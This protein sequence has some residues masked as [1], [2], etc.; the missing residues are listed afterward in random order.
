MLEA[1]TYSEDDV[2][3]L[4]RNISWFG[5][6]NYGGPD[7]FFKNAEG[8]LRM[9]E[10]YAK[11]PNKPILREGRDKDQLTCKVA[12]L[13]LPVYRNLE[14][15]KGDNYGKFY[16]N[17]LAA[18]VVA[19][20]AGTSLTELGIS[21]EH[22]KEIKKRTLMQFVNST[23][24]TADD[25]TSGKIHYSSYKHDWL[26]DFLNLRR[27]AAHILGTTLSDSIGPE[28]TEALQRM[29]KRF[30][31]KAK[32]ANWLLGIK[33]PLQRGKEWLA[34]VAVEIMKPICRIDGYT[35]SNRG[36]LNARDM[37]RDSAR[38]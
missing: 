27:Q 8:L 36:P 18:H 16:Q 23:A 34:K 33:P 19:F 5:C 3:N 17:V 12:K 10:D 21:D 4:I 14:S 6:H 13:I 1:M 30:G 11:E 2:R 26:T 25:F 7:V 37:P 31:I 15:Y 20:E 29:A 35:R 24:A 32:D 9:A 38:L 28:K 22:M